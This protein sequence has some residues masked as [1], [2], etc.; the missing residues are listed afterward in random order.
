MAAGECL[1]SQYKF[2]QPGTPI[3]SIPELCT[4]FDVGKT[5][6]YEILRGGKYGKEEEVEKK[7][8]KCIKPEP[9]KKEKEGPPTKTSKKEGKKSSA[10]KKS[11]TP[12]KKPKTKA[13]PTTSNHSSF[14]NYPK[15]WSFSGLPHPPKEKL[16]KNV[17]T[18]Y[19]DF[20]LNGKI[21][22]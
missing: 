7:P 9:V 17:R 22:S 20:L 12:K 19:N 18:K 4:Y 10:L 15:T 13:I 21:V 11:T 16:S 14:K 8:L 2:N 6:F 1:F 5:K 3:V